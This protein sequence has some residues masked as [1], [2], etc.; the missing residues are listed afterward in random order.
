MNKAIFLKAL[1]IFFFAVLLTT[2]VLRKKWIISDGLSVW[3]LLLSFVGAIASCTLLG[4]MSIRDSRK[5]SPE[6]SYLPEDSF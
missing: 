5:A 4:I 3:I 6:S 2:F 1:S